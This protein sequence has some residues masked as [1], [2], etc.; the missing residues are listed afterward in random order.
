MIQ[1]NKDRN[2]VTTPTCCGRACPTP[3]CPHCGAKVQSVDPLISLLAHCRRQLA[4]AKLDASKI[5]ANSAA[6]LTERD[7]WNYRTK[8]NDA[9]V[10]RWQAWSDALAQL[11]D[12]HE[13]ID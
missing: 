9:S 1:Q 2:T 10:A 11:I 6:E 5:A 7:H 8:R 12:Q 13:K 3:F 4:N